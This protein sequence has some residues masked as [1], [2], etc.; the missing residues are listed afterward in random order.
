VLSA[1]LLEQMSAAEDVTGARQV[2]RINPPVVLDLAQ[3]FRADRRGAEVVPGVLFW[4]LGLLD[5]RV[6]SDAD[7]CF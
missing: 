6:E 2:R 3:A 1:E 4:R 5:Q 7:R